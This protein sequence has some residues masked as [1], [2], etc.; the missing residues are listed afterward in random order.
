MTSEEYQK[1]LKRAKDETFVIARTDNG[2]RI[3]SPENGGRI[4][5]VTGN[6]EEPECSCPDFQHHADDPEWR[7][8]H[9]LAVLHRKASDE[10]TPN[11]SP[12]EETSTSRLTL[13]RSVSPDGKI[14]ALSVEVSLPVNGDSAEATESRARN[15]LA[16]QDAITT[17]FLKRNGNGSSNR[18]G[19][20]AQP[21]TNGEPVPATILS[22]GGMNGKWGRR[23]FLT[24]EVNGR[25]LRLYGTEAQ[26]AKRIR[27]AGYPDLAERVAEGLSLNVP[28]RVTTKPGKNPKY[29]DVAQVLP[30]ATAP[31]GASW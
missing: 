19:Q 10:E 31:S 24:F 15:V 1:R 18:S 25:N 8:K 9:V 7:C 4:Y 29:V 21:S 11:P 5:H 23:L 20:P 28:C 14:D 17:G 16:L 13:K 2:F 3:H 27:E 26:L 12:A 22:V 6:P 30:P